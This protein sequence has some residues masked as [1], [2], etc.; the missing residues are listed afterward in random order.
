MAR[1]LIVE[2][3][4]ALAVGLRNDLALEGYEVDL[5]ADG[6]SAVERAMTLSFDLVLLDLMLPRKDGFAVCRELRRAGVRTPII[7]LSA[8]TQDAEKVLG[9][10]LGADDYVTKPFSPLELRARI[11]AMLRRTRERDPGIC[12]V[13]AVD[14]DFDRGLA[15]R[16]SA[17]VDLTPLELKVLRAL[18][19]ADGRLLTRSQIVDAAWGPGVAISDRVVDN[20]VMNLRRK[21]EPEPAAPRY[22]L[23]A[24]GLGY[25][26][27]NPDDGG[28]GT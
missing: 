8:R 26:F 17:V 3:D 24:R 2:D 25:R 10:E 1:I 19:R 16:D 20:H 18:V 22:L 6:Q 4:P 27:E 21:L 7:V 9:F 13:G 23:S 11:A 15:R 14:V 12:R 28:T 5:V